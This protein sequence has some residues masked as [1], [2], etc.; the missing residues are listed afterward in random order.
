MELVDEFHVAM[1]ELE[2]RFHGG[3]NL[4]LNL[5]LKHDLGNKM[6][7]EMRWSTEPPGNRPNCQCPSGSLC[8]C[9]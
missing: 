7:D 3:E 8:D 6:V 5:C 1:Y 4:D 9:Y 2:K